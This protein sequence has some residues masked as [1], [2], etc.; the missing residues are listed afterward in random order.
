MGWNFRKSVKVFPGFKI[1]LSKKGVSGTV[2]M[3]GASVTVGPKG[4]YANA[5]IPGTG[6]YKRQKISGRETPSKDDPNYLLNTNLSTEYNHI[7]T[8]PL[9][10]GDSVRMRLIESKYN[11]PYILSLLL[12]LLCI[13]VN[14]FVEMNWGWVFLLKFATASITIPAN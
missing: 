7:T 8:Y 3:Q 1:N 14:F 5:S 2:G 12:P 6:I 13:V 11:V 10:S 9:I 4:V